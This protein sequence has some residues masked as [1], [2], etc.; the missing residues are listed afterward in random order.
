MLEGKE[1]EIKNE[2]LELL[3]QRILVMDGAMGTMLQQYGLKAGECPEMWNVTNRDIVKKIHASYLEAG[4]DIILTNTF[5]ANGLKLQKYGC[6]NRLSGF[7]EQGVKLALEAID[8]YKKFCRPP[9]YS[10]LHR[11]HW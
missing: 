8:D 1:R 9:L 6:R 11:P 5:G 3:N 7:N 10:G 4:A 2:F